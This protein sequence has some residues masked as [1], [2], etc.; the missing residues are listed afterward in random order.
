MRMSS[1]SSPE[2]RVPVRITLRIRIRIQVLL[3]NKIRIRIRI[4]LSPKLFKSVTPGI[5]TLKGNN[6]SLHAS[7][8]SVHGPS[9]LNFEPL[10]LLNFDPD[11]DPAFHFIVAPD[12]DPAS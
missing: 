11:P 2:A 12:P 3:L 7:V 4:L 9:G 5:K 10:K 8:G 6:L 1:L